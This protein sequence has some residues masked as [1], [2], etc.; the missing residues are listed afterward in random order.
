MMNFRLRE[1]EWSVEGHKAKC[2]SRDLNFFFF[3]IETAVQAP[4]WLG[5]MHVFTE[6]L[7]AMLGRHS[8]TCL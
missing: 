4:V 5:V 6:S 8:D 2:Q 1:F 3:S 7:S